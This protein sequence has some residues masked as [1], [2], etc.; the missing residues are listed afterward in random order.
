MPLN[1]K[2]SALLRVM[3]FDKPIGTFLLL[4]P[5]LWGLIIA[6]EGLP[7]LFLFLTFFVGAFVMRSAGCTTNDLTD[8]KLDGFVERTRDRPLVTG[9]V[10]VTEA[11]SLLVVLMGIALCLVSYTNLLTLQLSVVGALLTVVYPF[12]K[13]VTHLPQVVLGMAF[14]WSIPMAFAATVDSLPAGLW[15]LFCAN[16]LWVVVYDTQYAMVDREDDLEVGIK[17]TAIL[18]GR[19]DTRIIL[20]LQL[21]CLACFLATGLSFHLGAVYFVSIALVALLFLRHQR[22]ISDRSREACFQAFN[23]SK[24]IGFIV[25]AGLLGHYA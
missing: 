16:L 11:I 12:M 1:Q 13:R 4:A 17:S 5:A 22:L 6:A 9:D 10:S 8:R 25:V 24:W 21:L 14:S 7:S 23:E 15:W 18:F 3:R 20:M 19:A 2:V